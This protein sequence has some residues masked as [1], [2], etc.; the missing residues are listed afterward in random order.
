MLPAT[1][2]PPTTAVVVCR[3]PTRSPSPIS[4][5]GWSLKPWPTQ[6]APP[7][8]PLRQLYDMRCGHVGSFFAL[9]CRGLPRRPLQP[10]RQAQTPTSKSCGKPWM[11]PQRK[12]LGPAKPSHCERRSG[13][14]RKRRR[15]SGRRVRRQ[16]RSRPAQPW[17]SRICVELQRVF[18]SSP[19]WC[20][21]L[22]S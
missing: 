13:R 22:G 1:N 11:R 2:G 7:S 15:P 14:R 5:R 19:A 21:L 10:F 8:S 12:L 16:V 4:S 9:G 20:W 6:D 18:Q 17:V 3:S